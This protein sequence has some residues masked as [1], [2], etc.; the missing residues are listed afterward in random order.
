M[1]GSSGAM[2][3]AFY[4][5]NHSLILVLSFGAAWYLTEDSLGDQYIGCWLGLLSE[6]FWIIE[7]LRA[8]SWSIG[9]ISIV[10]ACLYIKGLI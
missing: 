3:K 1:L 8:K 7:S 4:I 2:R 10:Y 5:V 6:P 9:I